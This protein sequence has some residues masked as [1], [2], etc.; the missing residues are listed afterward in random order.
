VSRG[1]KGLPVVRK[2]KKKNKNNFYQAGK[3]IW[4][5]RYHAILLLNSILA[6]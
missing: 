1:Q 2:K 4:L 5:K 3:K 6:I